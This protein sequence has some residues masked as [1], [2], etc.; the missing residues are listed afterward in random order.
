[1]K[2]SKVG[3]GL[4]AGAGSKAKQKIQRGR[5]GEEP[6][7]RYTSQKQLSHKWNGDK[8]DALLGSASQAR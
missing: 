3:L 4:D 5:N 2:L 7:E 6:A 1:M 8:Q